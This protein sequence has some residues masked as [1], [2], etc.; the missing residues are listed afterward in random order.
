VGALGPGYLG[1][2]GGGGGGGGPVFHFFSSFFFVS[3]LFLGVGKSLG[4][5]FCG[6]GGGGGEKGD[7]SLTFFLSFFFFF[8]L[9]E[10]LGRLFFFLGIIY[11]FILWALRAWE[12]GTVFLFGGRGT[13]LLVYLYGG[14][15][16]VFYFFLTAELFFFQIWGGDHGTN[17]SPPSSV[18]SNNLQHT[19]NVFSPCKILQSTALTFKQSWSRVQGHIGEEFVL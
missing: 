11:F 19:H 18:L 10:R 5:F 4:P 17:R 7:R 8:F 3:K 1:G 15:S 16:V 2:G 6:G 13:N 12:T 9:W 14:T